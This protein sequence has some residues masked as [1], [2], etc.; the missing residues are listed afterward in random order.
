MKSGRETNRRNGK[1]ATILLKSIF[2][3]LINRSLGFMHSMFSAHE[4]MN[5]RTCTGAVGSIHFHSA[6]FHKIHLNSTP[7]L[8]FFLTP[9]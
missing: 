6:C 4:E 5:I 1:S 9:K 3:E 2:A 8:Q 7:Y